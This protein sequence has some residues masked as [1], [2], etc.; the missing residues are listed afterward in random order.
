MNEFA[1]EIPR[2]RKKSSKRI[3]MKSDHKHDYEVIEIK[4]WSLQGWFTY[5]EACKICGKVSNRLHIED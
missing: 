4:K 1:N 3:P 5:V 2:Y